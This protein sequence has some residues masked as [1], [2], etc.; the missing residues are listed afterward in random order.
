MKLNK[1]IT[2][3]VS[4]VLMCLLTVSTTLAQEDKKLE[5]AE[6]KFCQ[7]L[8]D[9]ADALVTLDETNAEST[10]DEFRS[11]YKSAEKAWNK[12]QKSATKLENVEIKESQKAYNKLVDEINKIDGDTKT[13]EATA[14]ID[15]H[16]DN[17]AAEI[18]DI[19]TVVCE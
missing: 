18:A 12:F 1:K 11:A 10:M 16:V 9:L 19:M 15:M 6:A 2:V 13:G 3:T 8:Y 17:T 7:S 4:C 5:K 14:E